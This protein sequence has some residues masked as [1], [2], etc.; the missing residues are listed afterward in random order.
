MGRALELLFML[1]LVV[2]LLVAAYKFTGRRLTERRN[3]P[4]KGMTRKD[5][6]AVLRQ[7]QELAL[8]ERKL[9]LGEQQQRLLERQQQ[10]FSTPVPR[11]IESGTTESAKKEDLP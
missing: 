9:E 6:S 2:A 7:Q 8:Q 1:L 11:P 4:L 5:R 3:N 10:F